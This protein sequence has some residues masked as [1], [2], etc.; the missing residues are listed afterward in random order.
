MIGSNGIILHIS[1]GIR[2]TTSSTP[3]LEEEAIKAS[4]LSIKMA[5][6]LT[7]SILGLILMQ[8]AADY[9]VS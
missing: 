4:V 5:Q 6:V 3:P 9:I 1:L 2:K 8:K 7:I